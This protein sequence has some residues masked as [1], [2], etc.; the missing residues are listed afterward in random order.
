MTRSLDGALKTLGY[1]QRN[2]QYFDTLR[3]SADA[4]RVRAIRA[5]AEAAGINF[6]YI[7]DPRSACRSTKR[8][9]WRIWRRW[10]VFATAADKG[11]GVVSLDSSTDGPRWPAALIR[12]SAYLT[13]R[14]STRIARRAR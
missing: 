1:Q 7:G 2:P 4:A 11:A 6:R 5:A 10:N 12:K 8:S 14:S 9:R 3:I 13:H